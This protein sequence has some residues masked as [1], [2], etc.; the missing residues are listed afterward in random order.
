MPKEIRE[1]ILGAVANTDNVKE[2]FE[3]NKGFIMKYF[4][5]LSLLL[6]GSGLWSMESQ[7]KTPLIKA[8][9]EESLPKVKQLL[10]ERANP[11]ES[12]NAGFTPLNLSCWQDTGFMKALLEHSANP[13]A[14]NQWGLIIGSCGLMNCLTGSNAKKGWT[15]LDFAITFGT[16]EHIELLLQYGANPLQI[17]DYQFYRHLKPNKKGNFE[18]VQAEQKKRCTTLLLCFKETYPEIPIEMREKILG[19]VAN[20]NNVKELFQEPAEEQK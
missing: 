12:N 16:K 1:K 17:R 13:N 19:K 2:L 5:T 9:K 14:K 4:Y 10:Q 11:N 20:T 15:E 8:V 7:K 3:L 18:F 6:A